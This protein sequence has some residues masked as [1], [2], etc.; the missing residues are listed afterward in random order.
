[1]VKFKNRTLQTEFEDIKNDI[2]SFDKREI[3]DLPV[4]DLEVKGEDA[5]VTYIYNGKSRYDD[6]Q[7]DFN[8]LSSTVKF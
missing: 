4:L 2:I 1:M 5:S 7:S 3:S 8:L 6:I